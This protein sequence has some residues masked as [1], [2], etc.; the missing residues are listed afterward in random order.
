MAFKTKDLLPY[1]LPILDKLPD[2]Q[3]FDI[4]SPTRYA[5]DFQAR[6]PSEV[7]ALHNVFP[8]IV[9]WSPRYISKNQW[10]EETA[11]LSD[12]LEV[13]IYAIPCP[14]CGYSHRAPRRRGGMG[15][16]LP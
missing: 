2:G 4:P 7:E 15:I 8:E 12:G 1:Y 6:K 3:W 9:D 14:T 5:L 10:W 11:T 16:S 13:R